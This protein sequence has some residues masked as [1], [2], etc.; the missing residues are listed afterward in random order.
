MVCLYAR[1]AKLSGSPIKHQLA[2]LHY[3]LL[4]PKRPEKVYKKITKYSKL[5]LSIF[6]H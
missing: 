1:V 5:L 2:I 3:T 4:V 6:Q